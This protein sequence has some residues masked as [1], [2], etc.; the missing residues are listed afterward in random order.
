MLPRRQFLKAGLGAAVAIPPGKQIT[1]TGA[2]PARPFGKTGHTLPLLACGGSA[3]VDAGERVLRGRRV[4]MD[5]VQ[6]ASQ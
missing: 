5:S 2:I 4:G 1:L 6:R 3:L